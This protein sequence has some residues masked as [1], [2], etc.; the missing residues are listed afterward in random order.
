VDVGNNGQFS[1]FMASLGC[2]VDDSF[3]IQP[4]LVAAEYF[5]M[6]ANKFEKLIRLHHAGL[7]DAD[8]EADIEGPAFFSLQQHQKRVHPTNVTMGDK[9]IDKGP[10][11]D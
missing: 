5:N 11:T 3:E 1:L 6:Q 10:R 9:C 4:H 8:F 2:S 7:S